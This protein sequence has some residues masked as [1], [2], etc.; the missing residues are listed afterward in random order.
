MR[1][2]EQSE[3]NTACGAL[4][5]EQGR[6]FNKYR[7]CFAQLLVRDAAVNYRVADTVKKDK[8]DMPLFHFLVGSGSPDDFING[9][10]ADR[11]GN[12]EIPVKLLQP[13]VI[14]L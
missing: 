3:A 5:V 9:Q 13:P 11:G 1:S 12:P 10:A 2:T 8:A 4:L 6:L 7:C 14:F